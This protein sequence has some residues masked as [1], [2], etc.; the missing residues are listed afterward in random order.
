MY[1]VAARLKDPQAQAIAERYASFGHSNLEEYWTLLW[2]D[3]ALK[4]AAMN[5][6][7]LAHH[8]KDSGVIFSRT[9]WN[10]DATAFA[11][12]AG[13]PEGHRVAAT[14]AQATGVAARQRTRASR[15]RQLRRSGRT[16]AI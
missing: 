2:R 11:F 4:P 14:A 1:R 15:C 7:P 8:F 5:D 9:S 13:P 12:K 6:I 3:P 10:A 16:A